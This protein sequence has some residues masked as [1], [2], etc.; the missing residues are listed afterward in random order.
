MSGLAIRDGM[1]VGRSTT[2][3][4]I[5][6]IE[7]TSGLEN[8]DQLHA[9]EVRLRVSKG[10][11]LALSSSPA[12]TVDL[13]ER[14]RWPTAFPWIIKTPLLPGD[15]VQTYTM[16]PPSPVS[17]P[18]IRHILLRPTDA[19]GAEFAIESVRLVFRRE[20]LASL[21]SGV[22]WQGLRDDLSRDARDP[23]ARDGAVRPEGPAEAGPR[24]VARARRRT[25]R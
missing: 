14:W 17:G 20:H 22:S 12:P 8:A 13:S 16:T 19:A 5:L 2:G 9:V 10:A 7:R 18:R 24:C 25:R 1:L 4:P 3:F 15:K 11:N 6:H 21:P 23:D